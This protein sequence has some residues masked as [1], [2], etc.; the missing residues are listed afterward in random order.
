MRIRLSGIFFSVFM[1]SL[2][3]SGCGQKGPLFM[4]KD[5]INNQTTEPQ[6]SSDSEN[7]EQAEPQSNVTPSEN[8]SESHA[9][10]QSPSDNE[11]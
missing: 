1:L 3:A 8:P 7:S 2:M 10:V 5:V 9:I 4:P 6:F 11:R